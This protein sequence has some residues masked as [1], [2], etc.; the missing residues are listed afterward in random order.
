LP[1]GPSGFRHI[2]FILSRFTKPLDHYLDEND[3]TLLLFFQPFEEEV[4]TQHLSQDVK[5]GFDNL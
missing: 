1:N 3:F 5:F 4:K 2:L